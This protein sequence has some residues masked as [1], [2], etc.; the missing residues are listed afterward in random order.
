MCLPIGIL[1]LVSEPG[2]ST[3]DPRPAN[4]ERAL[5]AIEAAAGEG[6]RLLVVGEA[7]LNGYA[8]G[9]HSE[10]W[11]V[12]ADA[13]DPFV[14]PLVE[15]SDRLGVTLVVGATTRTDPFPGALHNSALVIDHG[16]L[17]GVYSK[18]HVPALVLDD[19]SVASERSIWDPGDELR[20]FETH[21]GRIG[22]EICFDIWYPEVA[23][24]LAMKGAEL[25]VNVAASVRGFEDSW[26]HFLWARAAENSI[27]YL[28]V[29]VVGR[30]ND[31][32]LVGGSRLVGPTG[33][34]L[35][36]APHGEEAVLTTSLDRRL[37]AAARGRRHLL[38]SRRPAL[39]RA[40]AG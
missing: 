27:P 16:A 4:L 23:R 3:Y 18:T 34:V 20:V 7:Y 25:I 14:A 10:R 21:V 24:T 17:A 15:A 37:T 6:A 35:A 39:Y 26:D 8:T 22:V 30:Q 33:A 32:E 11:A 31:V 40:I 2:D 9:A 29:S 28:H 19:G 13:G 38:A 12:P 36:A 5:R 1:Q